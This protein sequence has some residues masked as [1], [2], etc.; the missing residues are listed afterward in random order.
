MK[1]YKV[2]RNFNSAKYLI[3]V[4]QCPLEFSFFLRLS[5]MS[6]LFSFEH[7]ECNVCQAVRMFSF[8]TIISFTQIP[9]NMFQKHM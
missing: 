1:G 6:D 2:L 4:D 7:S 8:I 3:H 5:E 9:E